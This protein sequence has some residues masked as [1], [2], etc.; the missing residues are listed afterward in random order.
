MLKEDPRAAL[1]LE[2][3]ALNNLSVQQQQSS[4][5]LSQ[6]MQRLDYDVLPAFIPDNL[7]RPL[8]A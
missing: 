2:V 3:R 8:V 1:R 5:I 6:S 4:F 7:Q